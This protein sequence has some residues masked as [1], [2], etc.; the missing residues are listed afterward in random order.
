MKKQ[1]GA[2]IS[3]VLP[4][5]IAEELELKP[6]DEILEINGVPLGDLI[7]MQIACADEELEVIL[8]LQDGSLEV[9]EIEKDY[10]EALGVEL[11]SAVFDKIRVCKNKCVFCFID[12][13]PK[14]MRPSLYIK[15]D[16]YRTSF[17]SG[18]FITL[19][20]LREIDMKRIERLHLSPMYISVHTTDM[21]LRGRM[22]GQ[23]ESTDIM[24]QLERLFD[25][26]IEMHLQIVLCPGWNDGFALER[27]LRDLYRHKESIISLA[28]VPV[29]LTKHRE[30]LAAL[31][32]VTR[33]I[34]N[35]VINQVKKW[36]D[37]ARFENPFGNFIYLS[38]EFYITAG[39][40][41]PP[42]DAYGDYPQLENGVGI[43]RSFIED[44]KGLAMLP[45][46]SKQAI[47][48]DVVCGCLAESI[49]RPL[50]E[51]LSI[52]NV[53]IRLLVVANKFFGES[54]TATGLLTGQ[55]IIDALNTLSERGQGVISPAVVLK[56]GAAVFLDDMTLDAFKQAAGVP[57]R[58]ADGAVELKQLLHYWQM[59]E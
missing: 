17:L 15:D 40:E 58:V 16:D 50:L 55:D 18:S 3:K 13:M 5:S 24:K 43:A 52:E 49:V 9:I 2:I 11:E 42:V 25:G 44:W 31:Q 47:T 22:L 39:V 45:A 12:Q 21:E 10:D 26:E 4:D 32:P 54:V 20:N 33:E 57:V 37:K 56:K 46:R 34:A 28:I 14:K 7:D 35:T 38:D 36:Q 53:K 29:G 27:T 8:R 6:G 59:E 19:S 48:L 41:V 30:K 51:Q 1:K 23:K